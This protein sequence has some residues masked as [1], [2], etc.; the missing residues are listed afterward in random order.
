MQSES[1]TALKK[2]YQAVVVLASEDGAIEERLRAAYFNHL[3]EVPT[4]CLPVEIRNE[5]ESLQ[6]ELEDLYCLGRKID[7]AKAVDLAQRILLVYDAL[8]R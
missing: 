7:S 4:T 8:I 2:L 5:C 6:A 1:A 3:R